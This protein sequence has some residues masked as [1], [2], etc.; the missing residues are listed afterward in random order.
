MTTSKQSLESELAPT[1][2][3]RAESGIGKEEIRIDRFKIVKKMCSS[4]I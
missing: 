2:E 1:I 3:S 4:L